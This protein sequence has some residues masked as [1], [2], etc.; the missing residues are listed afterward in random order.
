MHLCACRSLYVRGCVRIVHSNNGVMFVSFI[1]M[2][3]DCIWC[4]TLLYGEF[5]VCSRVD[6]VAGIRG[7]ML[8]LVRSVVDNR[9]CFVI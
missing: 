6:E 8:M 3:H 9:L 2:V 4:C 7:Y 5:P 1:A